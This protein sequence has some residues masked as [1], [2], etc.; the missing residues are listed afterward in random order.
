[1]CQTSLPR[2]LQLRPRRSCDLLCPWCGG[3]LE[4]IQFLLGRASVQTAERCIGCKQ[5]LK[6]GV[7]DQF[8]IS[9]VSD[10]A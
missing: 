1:M 9:V 4:Q 5:S 7:N 10:V 8:E 3:E 2:I 6:L